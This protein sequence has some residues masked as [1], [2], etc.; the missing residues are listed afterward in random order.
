MFKI[1]L[2]FVFCAMF[3]TSALAQSSIGDWNFLVEHDGTSREKRIASTP[4]QSS[5]DGEPTATLA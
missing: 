3:A 4:A 5:A 2:G 1:T